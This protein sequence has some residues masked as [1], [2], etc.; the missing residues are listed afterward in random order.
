MTNVTIVV[1]SI[2]GIKPF[3]ITVFKYSFVLLL[4]SNFIKSIF[5]FPGQH[6]VLY[7][8]VIFYFDKELS[9]C[10]VN[11]LTFPLW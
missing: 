3:F 2:V 8:S 6:V 5:K 7:S 4:I 10:S 9:S 1:N 11:R